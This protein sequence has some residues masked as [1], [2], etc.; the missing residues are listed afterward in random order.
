MTKPMTQTT[1]AQVNERRPDG[2][3]CYCPAGA[4]AI[5]IHGPHVHEKPAPQVVAECVTCS[6][7]DVRFTS[8]KLTR[9]QLDR[10]R[11]AGHDVRVVRP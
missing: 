7:G 5:R 1:K 8:D 4:D 6:R 10:H 3:P 9:S 11:A 2:E